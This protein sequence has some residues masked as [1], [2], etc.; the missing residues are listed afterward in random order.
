MFSFRRHQVISSHVPLEAHL[1]GDMCLLRDGSIF[2]MFGVDGMPWETADGAEIDAWHERLNMT[3]RNVASDQLV[4]TVYQCRGLADPTEYPSRTFNSAFAESLDTAYRDLLYDRAL[5]TNRIYLGVQF[6]PARPAGEWFGDQVEQRRRPAKDAPEDRV[7]RLGEICDLLQAE[8]RAYGPRRLG[9][10]HAGRGIFSEIAEAVV[11]AATGVWRP[12]G[13]TTGRLGDAMFS[14]DL[15][16]GSE[17]I[18]IR[19]TGWQTFAAMLRIHEYPAETWAGMFDSLLAA[20]YRYTLKHSFQCLGRSAGE[21]ILTRKQNKM[22]WAGD[23]ALS[24]ADGLRRAADELASNKFVMG[25][26]NMSLCLFADNAPALNRVATAAWK[27]MADSGIVVARDT[28]A[29]MAAWLSQIPGNLRLR[30]RPGG[31]SSICY[32]AMAPLHNYLEGRKRSRWGDP[33]AIFRSTGGT[34]IRFH[35]H[36]GEDDSAVGNTLIT[37]ETGSGKSLTTGFLIAMTSARAGIIALD[38]KRGWEILIR[39]MG[40][41]YAVL[42]QGRAHFAPLRALSNSPF[43]IEFLIE[44]FR[45]CIRQGGW[46]DLTEEEDRRLAL[47]IEEVMGAGPE[48]R[49]LSEVRAFLGSDPE[50]AGARLEKWCAGRELGWVLDAPQDA[51]SLDGELHGLDVTAL[52]EHPR[53]RGPAMLYLFHRIAVRLDGRPLLIPVDEGWRALM[54]EVFRPMIDKSLRTIRSK[55]GVLIFITQSPR[56]AI[57]SGIAAALIEQCPTSLDFANPRATKADYVDG[58]KRTEGEYEALR[59][60]R[61]G[62]GMFLFRQGNQSCV[63]QLPLHGLEDEIATLSA[64]EASL[65]I[66]DSLPQDVLNSPS[67]FLTEFHRARRSQKEPVA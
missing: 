43:N 48:D 34:P 37:G 9:I 30:V 56:D 13:L 8:L 62:S 40:G 55:N 24:Q 25:T 65:R 22:L 35:W 5:F 18:E 63:A 42:G 61:K 41:G 50:G 31:V 36:D 45:G 49:C 14:E 16:F 21:A 66:V 7:R 58:L 33:I 20:A 26:H 28:K 6:R 15:V 12:I 44:L 64:S 27:D 3:I 57:D 2:A 67:R 11:H 1:S 47:G 60:L 23:K 32:A 39:G 17:A 52:L 38:H 54:D 46:R 53:A 10:R 59:T 51:I 4:L 19:G 29:L